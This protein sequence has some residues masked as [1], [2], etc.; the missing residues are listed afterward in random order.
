MPLGFT[1]K[2]STDRRVLILSIQPSLDLSHLL[3]VTAAR[4]AFSTI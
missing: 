2:A 3:S 4:D 1:R